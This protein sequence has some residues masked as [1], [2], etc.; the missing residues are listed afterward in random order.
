MCPFGVMR[1]ILAVTGIN[2]F[3]G[4]A[5][6]SLQAVKRQLSRVRQYTKLKGEVV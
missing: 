6:I 2:F 3:I 1:S 5:G 4:I